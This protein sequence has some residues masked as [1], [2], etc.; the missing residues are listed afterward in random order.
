MYDEYEACR[1]IKITSCFT[2]MEENEGDIFPY[3]PEI[4][5]SA[6][7]PLYDL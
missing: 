7:A 5:T 4:S 6:S 2:V 1:W 3:I